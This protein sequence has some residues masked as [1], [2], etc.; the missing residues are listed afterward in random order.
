[1]RV[2]III[3]FNTILKFKFLIYALDSWKGFVN[4]RP[5]DHKQK[6]GRKKH[7]WFGEKTIVWSGESKDII[8]LSILTVVSGVPGPWSTLPF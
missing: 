2:I 1:M 3:N 6:K 5:V 4:V 7:N 8:V